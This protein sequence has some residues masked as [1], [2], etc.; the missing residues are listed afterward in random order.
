MTAFAGAAFADDAAD[1][2]GSYTYADTIEWAAEYDVVV[3]GM[4]FAGMVAAMEAA[5]AG[6]TV[7]L[8]DKCPDGMAGGNSR[9]CG[10]GFAYGSDDYDA[11][12]AYYS[13]MTGGRDVP[14]AVLTTIVDGV[15]HM[16]TTMSDKFGMNRDEF[17]LSS[18][19]SPEYPEFSGS[20]K[21]GFWLTHQGSS[22]SYLYKSMRARLTDG[23]ADKID[24]WFE[25]PGTALIQEPTA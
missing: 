10:Q 11:T 2:A 13:E 23:Y 19:S 9:V 3:L 25:T 1:A 5:D 14:E 17:I 18:D 7:L 22:D 6:A 24:V 12:F 15:A 4:G 16:A 20:D 21:V 8:C